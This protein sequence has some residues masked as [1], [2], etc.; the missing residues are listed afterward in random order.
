[1]GSSE[2]LGSAHAHMDDGA[3][4]RVSV[5]IPWCGGD[6]HRERAYTW[7]SRRYA[8][9]HGNWEVI[10][11]RGSRP[12]RKA[13]AVQDGIDKASGDI[14]VIADADVWC[15][16]LAEAVDALDIAP[17]VMPHRLVCRLDRSATQALYDFPLLHPGDLAGPMWTSD[18][19]PYIGWVGGG[20]AIIRRDAWN[21]APMD[22]RFVGWGQEDI[23]WGHA[24]DALVGDHERFHADLYH[25]WHPP[26]GRLNR[27]VGNRYG[28]T[29]WQ[30]YRSA[31]HRP[32][33]MEL[34]V[35]EGRAA[36]P[37]TA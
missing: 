11:G 13:L 30:R 15:D 17:W 29:L 28:E 21:V 1:M 25:L 4:P 14:F 24:L 8:Q 16:N 6:V 20:I 22:P 33:V 35:N 3:S 26:E 12:W 31:R 37:I 34:L 36:W 5:I 27:R 23:S 18:E 7:V 2:Q 10:E 9:H 32:D 19:P